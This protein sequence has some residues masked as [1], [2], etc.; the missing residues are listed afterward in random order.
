MLGHF[1]TADVAAMVREKGQAA[2]RDQRTAAGYD[3][4]TSHDHQCRP[5]PW[6]DGLI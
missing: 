4:I 3:G 2:A 6:S 1:Y 5:Q